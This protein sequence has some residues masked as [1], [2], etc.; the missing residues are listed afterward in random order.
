MYKAIYKI[1]VVLS[2]EDLIAMGSKDLASYMVEN[3]VE[4]QLVLSRITEGVH[5][6]QIEHRFIPK[7]TIAYYKP[8]VVAFSLQTVIDFNP[9]KIQ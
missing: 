7:N 6:C 4:K 8:G 9:H 5:Y 1:L 3:G 2:P